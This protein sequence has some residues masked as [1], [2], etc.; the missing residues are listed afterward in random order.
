MAA[1]LREGKQ[2]GSSRR[3]L[4]DGGR[5]SR[6]KRQPFRWRGHRRCSSA[7]EW[8]HTTTVTRRVG[9]TSS[10]AKGRYCAKR[11][12]EAASTH[13]QHTESSHAPTRSDEQRSAL[14]TSRRAACHCHTAGLAKLNPSL[15]CRPC[16]AQAAQQTSA[17]PLPSLETSPPQHRRSSCRPPCRPCH[18]RW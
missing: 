10:G 9:M 6:R 8:P 17:P 4:R 14:F 13:S 7:G 12:L 11:S 5:D 2:L 16:L 1:A 18:L 3:P 15:S